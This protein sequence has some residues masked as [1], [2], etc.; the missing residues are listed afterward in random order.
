MSASFLLN[1]PAGA[2]RQHMQPEL[3]ISK[4][5]LAGTILVVDD[6]EGVRKVLAR[7]T[8]DL[9]HAV[10]VAATAEEALEVMAGETIDVAVCDVKMPGKDGIWLVDQI[11]R[12]HPH[13]AI[14]MA[15]GMAELDPMVTLR[16]GVVGYIVKP[17]G[18]DEL[19]VMLQRGLASAAERPPSAPVRPLLTDGRQTAQDGPPEA[20]MRRSMMGDVIEGIVLTRYTTT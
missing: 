1:H 3:L 7:W 8:S 16:P 18:R 10:R 9:G 5:K 11:R 20:P 13:T 19:S 6:D 15:T 2:D 12:N 4:S 17:F 14:V